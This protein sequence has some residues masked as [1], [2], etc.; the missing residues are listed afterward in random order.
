MLSS[1]YEL[2][3]GRFDKPQ[4]RNTSTTISTKRIHLF[5]PPA[6]MPVSSAHPNRAFI[7][8][9]YLQVGVTVERDASDVTCY[10]TCLRWRTGCDGG[11]RFCRKVTF[12]RRTGGLSCKVLQQACKRRCWGD[13]ALLGERCRGVWGCRD[14][15]SDGLRKYGEGYGE[16]GLCRVRGMAAGGGGGGDLRVWST[17]RC[18]WRWLEGGGGGAA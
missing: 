7:D 9:L 16:G 18:E 10:A 13:I 6:V 3:V 14:L 15:I 12:V 17:C 5:S 4:M 1:V 2:T 8:R 11:G